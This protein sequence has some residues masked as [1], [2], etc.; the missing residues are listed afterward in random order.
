M[1]IKKL[2]LEAAK[3]VLPKMD[4]LNHGTKCQVCYNTNYI[5]YSV[6]LD[7]EDPERWWAHI[8]PVAQSTCEMTDGAQYDLIVEDI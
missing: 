4:I 1:Q 8:N 2:V 5:K 3:C 6:Q 7:L